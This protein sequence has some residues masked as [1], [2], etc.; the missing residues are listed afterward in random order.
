LAQPAPQPQNSSEEQIVIA[1]RLF[2]RSP[3][4]A[5]QRGVI[6]LALVLLIAPPAGAII[7]DQEPANDTVATAPIMLSKTGPVTTDAG[8]LV[9]V[10]GDIDFVG[11]AALSAGDVVTV[12]TTPLD[13]ADLQ[14]PDTI[15][16]LFDSN[17]T[18]PTHMILCR[19]D[20]T[21]N[22][23]LITGPGGREIGFGSLCRF[24]I[25][26]PGDYYV[27]V[28][29]FRSTNPPGCDPALGECSSFPFDGGIGPVPCEESG[30]ETF[31]CGNYQVT[32]AVNM[33]EPGVILQLV[34]GGIGLAWLNRRRDR[35]VTRSSQ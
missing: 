25:T 24:G 21:A 32:I 13:D 18:D 27:G 19:G 33:P 20:D 11:I 2:R 22:N 29:G 14:V 26:A 31:T 12:T 1:S 9:L 15:V 10:A 17:S 23:D 28:T 5:R 34:S 7:T 30:G 8:E 6:L 16:G 4:G 35:K 3:A